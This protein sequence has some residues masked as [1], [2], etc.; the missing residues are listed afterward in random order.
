MIN[1]QHII[2]YLEEHIT[3]PVPK[4]IMQSD[5][6]KAPTTSPDYIEAYNQMKQ[7]KWY[8]ELADEQWEDG[9]WGR[10][11]S[12]D[13]KVSAKQRFAT[14]EIALRRARELSLTK[15]DAIIA[16]CIKLMEQ[17]VNGEKTW[18]DKIEQHH[19]GGKSH[20]RARL[21][22][23]AANINLFDPDNPVVKSKQDDVVRTLKIALSKGYFDEV[24]WEQENRTYNGP[25]FSGWNAYPLMLLYNAYSLE[26]EIQRQYLD[27]IWHRKEG[28]YYLTGF[29][30]SDKI[31]LEDKRFHLWL[32]ALG[33]L[34]DFSLF[35]EFMRGDILPHLINE[36]NRLMYNEVVLPAPET[37]KSGIRY[38]ESWRDKNA[39]IID[40]ILRITRILVK[41]TDCVY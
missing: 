14:T 5:I 1:I 13:S 3:D 2:K 32:T 8:R 28:I 21:Y 29:P 22:I 16:K 27:Y 26:D 9:S 31:H 24:A 18:T 40:L 39:R 4:F 35:S 30:I 7:S 20:L 11:H 15:E 17:Y 23:T 33:Y 25:C 36:V 38:A 37:A 10:F 34:S 41:C 6:Y 12:M 19:D